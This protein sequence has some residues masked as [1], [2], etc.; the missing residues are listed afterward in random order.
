[1]VLQAQGVLAEC[2]TSNEGRIVAFNLDRSEAEKDVCVQQ[3][4]CTPCSE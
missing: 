3:R 2:K 1:M 4:L